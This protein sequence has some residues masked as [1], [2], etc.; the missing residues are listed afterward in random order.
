MK[1]VPWMPQ[2][3]KPVLVLGAVLL[4]LSSVVS[5]FWAS[6]TEPG[7]LPRQDPKRGFAGCGKRPPRVDQII[8]GVKVSLKWCSTCE[9]YRPP[10]SK[11]C[12]FCNNCVM[13][14]DHHCP[15]VANCIGIR[16]YRYFVCFVLSTFL[17]ALYV[18][19]ALLG[20]CAQLLW[21]LLIPDVARGLGLLMGSWS[22]PATPRILPPLDLSSENGSL[23]QG[24]RKLQHSSTRYAPC[25]SARPSRVSGVSYLGQVANSRLQEADTELNMYESQVY[26]SLKPPPV[27][28][29]RSDRNSM[30][31]HKSAASDQGQRIRPVKQDEVVLETLKMQEVRHYKVALPS[32]PVVVTVSVTRTSGAAGRAQALG[33]YSELWIE[34]DVRGIDMLRCM[35]S[36]EKPQSASRGR[37]PASRKCDACGKQYAC[38]CAQKSMQMAKKSAEM[39]AHQLLCWR[40]TFCNGPVEGFEDRLWTVLM[41]VVLNV[42][43]LWTADSFLQAKSES[44]DLQVKESLVAGSV[45]GRDAVLQ[46]DE[47]MDD[48]IMSFQEWKRTACLSSQS[49][50]DARVQRIVHAIKVDGTRKAFSKHWRDIAELQEQ[51]AFSI[52]QIAWLFDHCRR[53]PALRTAQLKV[54]GS[55]IALGTRI[56]QLFTRPVCHKI[57]ELT[58]Q[59]L[60]CFIESL[61]SAALPMDEFWLFMMAK[62]IQDTS[63]KFSPSQLVTIAECYAS[64]DLEDC[65]CTEEYFL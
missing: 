20:I 55:S 47:E 52:E 3:S 40:C 44:E 54:D 12:A 24:L 23:V 49:L 2:V 53:T 29:R 4:L 51:E 50:S 16:N 58:A 39:L 33:R 57:P 22:L 42:F 37:P 65:F 8:N 14:F 56:V 30:V 17:L 45:V 26:A 28:E 13:R 19:L 25:E 48:S 15:W 63:E 61:T 31:E 6:C 62:Q 18:L 43:A 36:K 21:D 5:L 35:T 38:R 59:Q 46:A 11:H 34:T 9:I 27:P 60:T 64:K 41:P 1:K 10:R 32:R 7:I